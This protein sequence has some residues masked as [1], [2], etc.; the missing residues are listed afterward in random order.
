MIQ[1][2]ANRS[3]LTR[4]NSASLS[5]AREFSF[6]GLSSEEIRLYHMLMKY[7]AEN[8]LPPVKVS[9]SL[10]YV[11]KCHCVDQQHST[12]LAKCNLHS[13]SN[14]GPWSPVCYTEDHSKAKFMWSKPS[15]LTPY[16]GYGFEIATYTSANMTPE[17]AFLLW[18]NSPPHNDL[19]LNK[20]PWKGK[21][22][23]SIG[24]G[25]STNY[26]NAWFGLENDYI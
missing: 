6:F 1:S 22:W 2:S 10:T 11:S 3:Q 24:I 7:R 9:K 20:G 12:P 8:G 4:N 14:R 19:I 25:M 23:K 26:C 17:T 15:E 13:W 16:K 21:E 5:S 18:K